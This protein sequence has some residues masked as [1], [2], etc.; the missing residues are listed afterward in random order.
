MRDAPAQ[1][2]LGDSGVLVSRQEVGVDPAHAH[3]SQV[4]HR[5]GVEMGPEGTATALIDNEPDPDEGEVA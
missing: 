5:C 2:D 1:C 4:C 3:G